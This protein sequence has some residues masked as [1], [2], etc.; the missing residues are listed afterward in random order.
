MEFPVFY[1]F[2]IILHYQEA[3]N[4]QRE[5]Q[6]NFSDNI[7]WDE[8]WCYMEDEG[9][10]FLPAA[11]SCNNISNSILHNVGTHGYY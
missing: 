9:A 8:Q 11:G 2:L 1:Y 5:T 7:Y 3:V 6:K 4:H 10:V